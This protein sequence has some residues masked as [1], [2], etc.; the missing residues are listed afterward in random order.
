M[1]DPSGGNTGISGVIPLDQIGGN[2]VSVKGGEARMEA[3]GFAQNTHKPA[4]PESVEEDRR[5][6]LRDPA[7][8]SES[9]D[10]SNSVHVQTQYH[11]RSDPIEKQGEWRI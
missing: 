11:V 6:I 5:Q 3:Y 8:I 10:S 2:F 9:F 7:H 4:T 1:Q